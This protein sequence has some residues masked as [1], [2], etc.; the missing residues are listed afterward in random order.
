MPVSGRAGTLFRRGSAPRSTRKSTIDVEVRVSAARV[1]AALLCAVAALATF[2]LLGAV[3][4]KVLG[5][6]SARGLIPRL[7]VSEEMSLPT[8]FSSTLLLVN[9]TLFAVIYLLKRREQDRF[10]PDWCGLATIFWLLSMEEI[11]DFHNVRLLSNAAM[12]EVSPFLRHSGVI[13]GAGVVVVVGAA[14][15]RFLLAL[16]RRTAVWMIV[17]GG[18]YVG[19]AIG[20]EMVSG[21]IVAL[22]GESSWA[23]VFASTTEETLEMLGAVT[24]IATSVRYLGATY[25]RP[26]LRFAGDAPAEAAPAIAIPGVTVL[27]LSTAASVPALVLA[28]DAMYGGAAGELLA[29]PV[30]RSA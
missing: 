10:A 6:D 20:F 4:G 21:S 3:S 28:D 26:V 11:A 12:S 19:G 30:S 15:A 8:W 13:L 14:Y 27:S 18:T 29:P 5:H 24:L 22:G 17:A 7:N 1:R 23:L 9:G 25:G 16:P 2:S